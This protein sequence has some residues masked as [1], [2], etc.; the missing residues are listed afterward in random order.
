MC[1]AGAHSSDTRSTSPAS[2]HDRDLTKLHSSPGIE[3]AQIAGSVR[4]S[5]P[6]DASSLRLTASMARP[7]R[8][9][10]AVDCQLATAARS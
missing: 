3:G 6:A 8:A 9:I 5:T 2:Q 10:C 1:R 7:E 4:R